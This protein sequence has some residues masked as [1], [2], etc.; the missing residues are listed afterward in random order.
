M[1]KLE[2]KVLEETAEGFSDVKK[3]GGGA[4]CAVFSGVVYDVPVAIKRLKDGAIE[5]EA[6]QFKVEMSILIRI[7]HPSICRLLAFSTDGPQRCLVLEL[8]TGGALDARIAC[9]PLAGHA[10]PTPLPWQHRVRLALEIA[11]A[12]AYLH[13]LKPEPMIHRFVDSS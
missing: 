7:S 3:I 5:W 6:K 13:S 2:F 10:P 8:C 1:L 12:L 11:E 4:S 9:R